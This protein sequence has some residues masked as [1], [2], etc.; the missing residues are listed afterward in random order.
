MTKL[1]L[2]QLPDRTPIKL[3]ISILPDLSQ[4]LSEYAALYA[5]P[6]GGMSR[7]PN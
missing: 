1:K 7:Y 6:M 4:A 5:K 3:S 2:A